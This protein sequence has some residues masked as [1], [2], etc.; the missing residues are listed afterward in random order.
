MLPLKTKIYIYDRE[1]HRDM[2]ISDDELNQFSFFDLSDF[3]L[4]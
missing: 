2:K 1:N 4:H 3:C